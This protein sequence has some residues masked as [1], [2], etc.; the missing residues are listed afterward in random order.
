MRRRGCFPI[1]ADSNPLSREAPSSK[2]PD[3]HGLQFRTIYGL[4]TGLA[5]GAA[6]RHSQRWRRL[7]V[8]PNTSA[9]GQFAPQ[10]LAEYGARVALGRGV[11]QV[12]ATVLADGNSSVEDIL[13]G[14]SKKHDD[15]HDV[16]QCRR[17]TGETIPLSRPITQ[18]F[19]DLKSF[20]GELLP[21]RNSHALHGRRVI[22]ALFKFR[23]GV[24][25][26]HDR[27]ALRLQPFRAMAA[28]SLHERRSGPTRRWSG[29]RA[30][31]SRRYDGSRPF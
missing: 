22:V 18:A 27:P 7:D 6:N 14:R 21:T 4:M 13:D 29:D 16:Y 31:A 26:S 28:P 2:T 11:E 25:V 24:Q 30:C 3:R 17:W 8:P 1:V 10:V 5:N 20:F 19:R 23:L 9:S 15:L 12:T